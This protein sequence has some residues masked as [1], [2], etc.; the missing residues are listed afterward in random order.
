MREFYCSRTQHG[1]PFCANHGLLL[2]KYISLWLERDEPPQ[3][4]LFAP[5]TT[6]RWERGRSL[7][8]GGDEVAA[9]GWVVGVGWTPSLSFLAVLPRKPKGPPPY[10]SEVI[11]CWPRS[12]VNP[13]PVYA[14]L[15]HEGIEELGGFGGTTL[16]PIICLRGER[17]M[18]ER[19][20]PEWGCIQI[21]RDSLRQKPE[22]SPLFLTKLIRVR[23]GFTWLNWF[24]H[25]VLLVG[26]PQCLCFFFLHLIRHLIECFPDLLDLFLTICGAKSP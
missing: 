18:A 11:M 10:S 7:R 9:G 1:S 25:F 26:S 2:F 21:K 14:P 4:C 19:V 12:A 17:V 20:Y 22:F 24:W 5:V 15:R 6:L 23:C 13:A 8:G 16:P 3:R